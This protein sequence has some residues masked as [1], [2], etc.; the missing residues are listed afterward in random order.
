MVIFALSQVAEYQRDGAGA[1]KSQPRGGRK[2][3]PKEAQPVR[4]RSEGAKGS[5]DQ[6]GLLARGLASSGASQV[7][8]VAGGR[9]VEGHGAEWQIARDDGD[10][11]V[12]PPG[13]ASGETQS[14][15]PDATKGYL[16]R[17]SQ[18]IEYDGGD[19]KHG[20]SGNRRLEHLEV[21]GGKV[22]WDSRRSDL[23]LRSAAP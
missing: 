17:E 3:A 18:V 1:T 14:P 12:E 20:T 7:G 15:E 5:A 11:E 23:P 10:R 4:F 19:Q 21:V 2:A 6:V 22:T 16:G 9:E 13:Q 8:H